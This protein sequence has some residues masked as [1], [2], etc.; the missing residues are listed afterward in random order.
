MFRKFARTFLP[1]PLDRMIKRCVKKKGKKVLLC[2]NRGLGDIALGLYAIVQRIR[3]YIPDAEITFLTRENLLAGFSM[4]EGVKAVG[5]SDWKRGERE[6]IGIDLKEYDLVIEKPDP[7]EWV[8]WQHGKV[9]PRLKWDP[10]HETLGEKFDLPSGYTYIGVQIAAE[11]SYGLWR[12][13][14]LDRWLELFERLEILG[15]YK[16]LLFGFGNEPQIERENVIDLRGKTTLFEF[17][18][19]M[20]NRCEYLILPDSGLLSMSYYLD[21]QFPMQILSLWADPKH[22][23]LKQN[24]PSPNQLLKH[25]PLV[26]DLRDLSQI[27]VDEVLKHL[28][29]TRPLLHAPFYSEIQEKSREKAGLIILAGGQGT[30]L[31]C[32]GPK[33]LFQVHG[34]SLFEWICKKA[35]TENFPIAIMTS[36]LNHE[37]TVSFFKEKNFFDREIHFFRQPLGFAGPDG[38]G[39][40]FKAF[41][42]AGLGELFASKQVEVVSIVQIDNALADPL[43]G[44]LIAYHRK[45]G[46][47]VT[48]KCVERLSP[49]ESMGALVERKGHIEIVEYLDLNRQETYR[50]NNTGMMVMNLSFMQEMASKELPI[51][52][53]EK[54]IDSKWVR[55]GEKF[56]FDALKYAKKVNALCYPRELC[57][58]PLK[59][60]DQ[61]DEIERKLS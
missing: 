43:D 25:I 20:K 53:V 12:N 61:L 18:S 23:I 5:V 2:W 10:S 38:N 26:G 51:H 46:S 40:V 58:A 59:S 29:P 31:N 19:L 17:L 48:L 56:I 33:G 11:T 52:W 37:A 4:L 22:G 50:Y 45:M 39:S 35:P 21:A 42:D 34:R 16:I 60:L 54:K 1:N 32:A 9:I 3:E 28:V 49:Q 44:T 36:P 6:K 14:P 47:D 41:Q 7:S 8:R 30:R 27:S 55:K 57:Y 13:W 24:V 15:G